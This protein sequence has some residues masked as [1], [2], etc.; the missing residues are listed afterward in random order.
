MYEK[1]YSYKRASYIWFDGIKMWWKRLD[2]PF[3]AN[4][5]VY[6]AAISSYSYSLL[7]EC[8]HEI[9]WKLLAT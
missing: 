1:A 5:T 2:L 3:P 7:V 4:I 8:Q 9:A 6:G